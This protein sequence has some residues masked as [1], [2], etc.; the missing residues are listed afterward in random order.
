[1]PDLID[2]NFEKS[3]N[4]FECE[5]EVCVQVDETVLNENVYDKCDKDKT[6]VLKIENKRYAKTSFCNKTQVKPLKRL[7]LLRLE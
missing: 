7:C 3:V 6:F 2:V 1:M 4:S 5:S